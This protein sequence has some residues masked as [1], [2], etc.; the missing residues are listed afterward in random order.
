M[1]SHRS[2]CGLFIIFSFFAL[3]V[4]DEAKTEPPSASALPATPAPLAP[5][6]PPAPPAA[7]KEPSEVSKQESSNTPTA[8]KCKST[9][10]LSETG[11]VDREFFL[12]RIIMRSWKDDG[13]EKAKAR[14]GLV[15]NMQCKGNEVRTPFGCSRRSLPP[16][17]E[18]NR[19]G[20]H[21]SRVDHDQV[22]IFYSG[23]NARSVRHENGMEK[24]A[25]Y[26]GPPFSAH[27]RPRKNY[28]LPGRLLRTFRK[29]RPY[30]TLGKDGQCHRKKGKNGN[31]KH[32]DHVYGLQKRHRHEAQRET[33]QIEVTTE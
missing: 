15:D 17:R 5:P 18:S 1:Q 19:V 9:E 27:N 4:Q 12:N 28:I 8:S 23:S 30:E 22:V 13:F 26:S 29:C 11:C 10:V 7:A 25:P 16:H 33:R 14:A 20:V 2:L 24:K 32:K 21:H 31:Y 3:T 6:A